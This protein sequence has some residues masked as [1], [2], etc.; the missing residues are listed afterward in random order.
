MVRSL[1]YQFLSSQGVL[2]FLGRSILLILAFPFFSSAILSSR[3]AY[4]GVHDLSPGS[5]DF[6]G[7]S[8]HA[9]LERPS[10][11]RSHF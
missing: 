10:S 6:Y 3:R 1:F 7:I 2:L 4:V 5:P 8:F 11:L 9:T